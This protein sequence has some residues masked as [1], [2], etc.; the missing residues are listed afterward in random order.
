MANVTA[1]PINMTYQA[2][3]NHLVTLEATDTTSGQNKEGTSGGISKNKKGE[4][5]GKDNP[6]YKN[7]SG[8]PKE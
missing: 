8:K 3:M 5:P 4:K 2:L 6:P 7:K 1:E